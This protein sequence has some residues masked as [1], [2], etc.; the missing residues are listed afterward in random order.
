VSSAKKKKKREGEKRREEDETRG[1][2][3]GELGPGV[4]T[5]VKES[6]TVGKKGLKENGEERKEH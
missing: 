5:G 3:G 2:M 1:G 6:P 4:A